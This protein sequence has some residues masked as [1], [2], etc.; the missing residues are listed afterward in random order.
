ME[1]IEGTV[2]A[3]S[4]KNYGICINETWYNATGKAKEYI[5]RDLKNKTVEFEINDKKKF[6]F[7]KITGT[8]KQE[9]KLTA[10]KVMNKEDWEQKER[11]TIR[12]E[13]IITLLQAKEPVS[14]DAIQLFEQYIW[15]DSEELPVKEETIE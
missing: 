10:D 8:A 4:E 13:L 7:I 14:H 15:G 11:R 9:S 12:K 1:K 2:K 3:I 5:K 6:E